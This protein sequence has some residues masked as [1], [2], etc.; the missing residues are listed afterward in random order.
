VCGNNES[1]AFATG[2]APAWSEVIWRAVKHRTD[3]GEALDGPGQDENLVASGK[4]QQVQIVFAEQFSR[5]KILAGLI[6]ARGDVE[7]AVESLCGEAAEMQAP[8]QRTVEIEI[9]ATMFIGT[10][11]GKYK[12]RIFE[13][14]DLPTTKAVVTRPAQVNG[15]HEAIKI[16]VA[17]G[18]RRSEHLHVFVIRAETIYAAL[19]EHLQSAAFCDAPAAPWRFQVVAQRA[20][21]T[22][23]CGIDA[24]ARPGALTIIVVEGLKRCADKV[25]KERHAAFQ[26]E[27]PKLAHLVLIHL[28]IMSERI[29]VFQC[30][31]VPQ[32]RKV[33]RVMWTAVIEHQVLSRAA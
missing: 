23:L 28:Q 21:E 24:G 17:G 22:V 32:L 6:A 27:M 25:M 11:E 26:S 30:F 12:D 9:A 7:K 8:A 18:G 3:K 1:D 5:V 19:L 4:L 29:S 33:L 2:S 13:Q 10:K 16:C 20:A 15:Q 31:T 14:E